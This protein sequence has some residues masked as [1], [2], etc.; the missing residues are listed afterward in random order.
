[1]FSAG[2]ASQPSRVAEANLRAFAD[3]NRLGHQSLEDGNIIEY[4]DSSSVHIYIHIFIHIVHIC[5]VCI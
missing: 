2:E 4:E 1:M 5:M 3:L